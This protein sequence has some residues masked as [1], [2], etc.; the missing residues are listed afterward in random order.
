MSTDL[1]SEF[2]HF[3]PVIH[4]SIVQQLALPFCAFDDVLRLLWSQGFLAIIPVYQSEAAL[5]IQKP[6]FMQQF[7]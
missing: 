4:L 5:N 2:T 7:V 6:P 1:T 3:N